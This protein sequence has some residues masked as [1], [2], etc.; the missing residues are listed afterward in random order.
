MY[1][2]KPG[3][4]LVIELKNACFIGDF[5]NTNANCT[6][7]DVKNVEDLATGEK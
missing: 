4:R 7:I 6:R 2:F 3:Q 1:N 5:L